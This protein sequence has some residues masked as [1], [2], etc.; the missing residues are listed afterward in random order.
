MIIGFL[1]KGGS[2]KSTLSHNFIKHLEQDNLRVLAIDADH[3]MDLAYK[4]A[5]TDSLPFFGS[6]LSELKELS[7]LTSDEHYSKA[8]EKNSTKLFSLS[9]K[10]TYTQKYSLEASP[11]VSLMTA[12]PHN[13]TILSGNT[14]SHS[15][16]TPLKVYLPLLSLNEGEFVVV[17]EKAGADGAS[18][19]VAKHFTHAVVVTEPTEY[20]IKTAKQIIDLLRA[21]NIPFVIAGNK[22]QDKDDEV[23]ILDHFPQAILFPYQ[24]EWSRNQNYSHPNF[25]LLKAAHT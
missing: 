25:S 21:Q 10:D 17:D 6:S 16:F 8:V 3:N 23:Y 18:S 11:L 14:C 4:I 5:N 22:I 24:K 13:D 2:G 12:G 20:S 15:L 1:G 7:G 19:G 9:P